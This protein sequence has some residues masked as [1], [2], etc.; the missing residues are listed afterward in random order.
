MMMSFGQRRRK[1]EFYL[2]TQNI[3]KSFFLTK[4]LLLPS[5]DEKPGESSIKGQKK[6]KK[7][8]REEDEEGA[9]IFDRKID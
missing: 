4:I 6:S 2:E 1:I 7:G 5:V 8:R 3:K 9:K